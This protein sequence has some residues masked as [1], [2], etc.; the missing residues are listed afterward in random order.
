MLNSQYPILCQVSFVLM[1]T[2]FCADASTSATRAQLYFPSNLKE[3][4]I[5]H[6]RPGDLFSFKSGKAVRILVD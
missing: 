5:D 1:M 6:C 4:K 2:L 3:Q